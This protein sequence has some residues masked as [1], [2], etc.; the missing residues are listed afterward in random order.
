MTK[1]NTEPKTMAKKF[2]EQQ[3][4]R[5]VNIETLITFHDMCAMPTGHPQFA[6]F[7]SMICLKTH[8]SKVS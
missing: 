8:K 2:G 4:K 6:V 7:I 3:S 1:T 5:L